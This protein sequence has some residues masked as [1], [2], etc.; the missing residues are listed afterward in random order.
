[1]PLPPPYRGDIR[2]IYR[3]SKHLLKLTEDVLSLS[4][5]ESREMKIHPE[6]IKL[7]EVVTEAMGIIRPLMRGKN[8]E[9]R[10]ELPH[11]LPLVVVDRARVGQ[12]LRESF[13]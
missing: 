11:D 1:M 3:S 8:V 7:H 4:K 6:P 12:V 13:E 2:E 5:I 9:L 10:A